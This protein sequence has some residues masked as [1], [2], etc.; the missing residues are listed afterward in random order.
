MKQRG[1]ASDFKLKILAGQEPVKVIIAPTLGQ[2][3]DQSVAKGRS[4]QANSQRTT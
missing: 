1:L 2:Q 4:Q 3:R